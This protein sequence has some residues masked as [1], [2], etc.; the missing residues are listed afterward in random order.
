MKNCP[1]LRELRI[2]GVRSFEDFSVM[3][4]EDVDTLEVIEIGNLTE[5]SWSF[6]YASLEL[7]SIVI[8]RGVMTR[9]AFSEVTRVR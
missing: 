3:E 8:S 9:H 1:M 6:H 7:R 4:I 2:V 5:A